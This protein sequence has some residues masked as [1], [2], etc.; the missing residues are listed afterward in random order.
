[1]SF[2]DDQMHETVTV[3]PRAGVGAYGPQFAAEYEEICYLEPGFK[4]IT[5]STGQ[6]VVASLFGIF[7]AECSIQVADEIVW[8]EQTYRAIAVDGLRFGGASHHV[9]AYF[10]SVAP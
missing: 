2:P 9:E 6:E 4:L 10:G 8:N 1:M 5:D 7:R 3:R